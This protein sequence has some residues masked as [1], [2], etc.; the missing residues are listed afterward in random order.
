M[1]KEKTQEGVPRP[2]MTPSLTVALTQLESKM[3]DKKANLNKALKYIEKA[4][5]KADLI[6]F[7]EGYLTGY[8][9]G[10]KEG[11]FFKLAEPIPGPSTNILIEAA[12]MHNMYIIMGMPEAN[13]ECPG[14]IHNSAAFLGPGGVI[15]IFRKIHLPTFPPYKEIYYGFTPGDEILVWEIKQKWKIGI[16][17]CY[18]TWFPETSRI[19]TIKGADLLVTI[20]AGP[21]GYEES[22]RILNQTV[23]M[24]NTIFH[25]YSNAVGRQWGNFSFFGG[26]HAISPEGVFIAKGS[27]NEEALIFATLNAK[28]LFDSRSKFLILRDRRPSAYQDLVKSP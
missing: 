16:L 11:L 24:T 14:I 17:I 7:P 12:K 5:G 18:D 1:K 6:V 10:E 22:W 23:A 8:A 28:D 9:S 15:G 13:T 25:V 2:G 4:S 3:A 21:S 19:V 20:S 27:F 26:A